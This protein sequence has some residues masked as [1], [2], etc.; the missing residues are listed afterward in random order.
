ML[1]HQELTFVPVSGLAYF[2]H[3]SKRPVKSD[4]ATAEYQVGN[5]EPLTEIEEFWRQKI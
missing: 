3:L 1:S 5:S 2:L 4:Q